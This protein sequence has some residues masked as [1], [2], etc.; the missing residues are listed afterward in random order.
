MKLGELFYELGFKE[1]LTKLDD[2]IGMVGNLDMKSMFAAAGLGALYA[3]TKKVMEIS[4]DTAMEMNRFGVVTG[5]SSQKMKQW[6]NAAESVGVSA[7]TVEQSLKH[8]Q[9]VQAKFKMNQ[10]D[11]SFL[12]GI[13]LLNEYGKAGIDIYDDAFIMQEKIANGIKKMDADQQRNVLSLMGI[14]EQMLLIYKNKDA[15]KSVD[16][17]IVADP[18]TVEKLVTLR[19]KLKRFGQNFLIIVMQIGAFIADIFTPVIHIVDKFTEFLAKE[20]KKEILALLG[21]GVSAG[22]GNIPGVVMS[23]AVLADSARKGTLKDVFGEI[24]DVLKNPFFLTD[25]LMM[26]MGARPS[27]ASNNNVT[28]NFHINGSDP[29]AMK[30]MTI[31][32]LN[33]VLGGSYNKLSPKEY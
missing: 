32:A 23:G 8:I 26:M 2:F 3:A 20:A 29:Q 17:R 15:L 11:A 21:L 16:D 9:M 22:T 25:P 33:E 10:P 31:E 28:A 12:Q 7:G 13:Y 30:H 4:T 1:D 24:L 18:E 6:S 19:K 14:N 5:M 27:Q